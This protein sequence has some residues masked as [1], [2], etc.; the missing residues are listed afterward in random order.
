MD[1]AV[2][3]FLEMRIRLRNNPEARAI[4]DRCLSLIARSI[5]ADP[6]TLLALYREVEVLGDELALRFGAPKS[7][8]LH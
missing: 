2:G 5:E 8:Q 1:E 6:E 7:L 3:Y 4:I